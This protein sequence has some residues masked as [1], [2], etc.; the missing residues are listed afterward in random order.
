MARQMVYEGKVMIRS[1][2]V[3]ADA[4]ARPVRLVD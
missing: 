1:C 4:E 2:L 3:T